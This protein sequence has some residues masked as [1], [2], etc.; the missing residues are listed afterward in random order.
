MMLSR[1]GMLR[2]KTTMA[3]LIEVIPISLGKSGDGS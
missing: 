2:N 3:I 1:V